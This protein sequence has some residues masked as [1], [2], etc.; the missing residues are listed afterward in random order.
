MCVW[1]GGYVSI[2][3][4]NYFQANW[5]KYI[6]QCLNPII[7]FDIINTI[8]NVFALARFIHKAVTSS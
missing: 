4:R 8:V 5:I 1:G 6:F 3:L 7:N 2:K